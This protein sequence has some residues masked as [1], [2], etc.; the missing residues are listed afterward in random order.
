MGKKFMFSKIYILYV[1]TKV[2]ILCLI[3]VWERTSKEK[4]RDG[5]IENHKVNEMGPLNMK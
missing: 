5:E 3:K 4:K 1:Y 2:F